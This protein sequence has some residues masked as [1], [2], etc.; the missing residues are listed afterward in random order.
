MK[1]TEWMFALQAIA[2][3]TAGRFA[4]VMYILCTEMNIMIVTD[5]CRIYL[6]PHLG[7]STSSCSVMPPYHTVG[8]VS[9][10]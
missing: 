6:E 2:T 9:L 8:A 3:V 10:G 7:M 4:W 1:K 5:G